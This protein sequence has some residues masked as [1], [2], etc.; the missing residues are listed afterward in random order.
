MSNDYDLIALDMDGTL[1]QS[2]KTISKRTLAAIGKAAARGKAVCLATGRPLSEILPYEKKL[3]AIRCCMLESGALLWDSEKK[4]ILAR[5][6][7]PEDCYD[8]ILEASLLEDMM[9]QAMSRGQSIV[10]GDEIA[11]MQHWHMQVYEPLYREAAVRVPDARAWIRACRDG[12]EKIN[13]YHISREA[14]IRTSERL[15]GLPMERIYAETS[16]LELSPKGVDKG[17]G[18]LDLCRVL[19]IPASRAIAVGDAD[20]DLPMIRAAGLG[21][22][23]GNAN[24]H[25]LKEA[26]VTV[27]TNDEDGCAQAIDRF[28]LGENDD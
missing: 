17:S 5:R 28:L 13:L 20:N 21:I 16:S 9:V 14:S 23:M 2:D 1:L 4:K 18:L 22:A 6:T 7:L 8:R 19:G 26:Q 15:Q 24:D 25:V 27:G 11:H 12:I 3:P 10:T